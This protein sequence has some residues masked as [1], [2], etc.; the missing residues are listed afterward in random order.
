MARE[1]QR[2][3][4][5]V[6][7]D[8]SQ[9]GPAKPAARRE[10]TIT[11]TVGRVARQAFPRLNAARESVARDIANATARDDYGR[12]A[13]AVARGVVTYPTGLVN[14]VV[15]PPA[16]AIFGALPNFVGGLVGSQGSSEVRRPQGGAS[17]AGGVGPQGN[18]TPQQL[19]ARD[20]VTQALQ[21]GRAAEA[22]VT[23]QDRLTAFVD[24]VFQRPVTLEQAQM[25]AGVLPASAPAASAKDKAVGAATS[26]ADATYQAEIQRAQQLQDQTARDEAIQK[27]TDRY[28]NRLATVAGANVSNLS[29]ADFANQPEE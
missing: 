15:V 16:R 11:D 13:G 20:S 22:A 9:E 8:I 4:Y 21:Q 19:A 7:T 28:F 1:P 14:D 25:A 3:Q 27:A 5:P 17:V 24:S 10:P 26:T 12:A 23:P 29:L 18:Y 2:R 6:R